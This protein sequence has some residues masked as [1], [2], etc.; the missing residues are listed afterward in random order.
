MPLS[1][2]VVTGY[3][4]VVTASP[5]LTVHAN[6]VA[7]DYVG[8]SGVALTLANCARWNGGTGLIVKAELVDKAVQKIAGEL[9][10]FDTAPTPPADSATWA[11]TDAEALT[12]VGIIP[13]AAASYYDSAN[14]SICISDNLA[15]GFKC[16]SA[17]KDLYAC[18]VTRGAPTY[19]SGDLNFRLTVL[20]D[21]QG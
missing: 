21:P 1:P 6:Y 20:Q 16:G 19:A 7:N 9:W 15:I 17:S 11:I 4:T 3:T 13:F 10:I 12:V 14:N 2:Q 5:T 8:Q 18:F